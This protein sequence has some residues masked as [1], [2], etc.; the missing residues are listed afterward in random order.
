M[1]N[2]FLSE[3][4]RTWEENPANR[5]EIENV[6]DWFVDKLDGVKDFVE[7]I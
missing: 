1:I 4:I 7:L 2:S 3:N 6:H 5:I